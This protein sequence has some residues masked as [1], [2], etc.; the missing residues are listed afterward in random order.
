MPFTFTPNEY[1]DMLLIFGECQKNSRAAVHLYQQRFPERR[2]PS[3]KTYSYVETRMREGSFPGKDKHRQHAAA[4]RTEEMCINVLAYVQVHPQISTRNLAN[5]VHISKSSVQRILKSYNFHP[6]KIHL[7]QE[8]RAGDFERRI[9]LIA[10]F[11]DLM[12][13][14]PNILNQILWSDESRF[15]NNATVN[16]HNMHYWSPENPHW[17]RET[18]FQTIWGVNVWCGLF[19]GRLIGPY[20]FQGT[21]TGARYLHFLENALPELL[22]EIPIQERGAMWWQ[23]D[24]APP[25]NSN[26]VTQFLNERFENQWIGN[27]GP[28]RW[29][30][31]SPD[32]SPLDFFL[33]GYLKTVVFETQPLNLEDLQNKIVQACNNITPEMITASCTRE[34]IRRFEACLA[35]NGGHFEQF[36]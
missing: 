25:H 35:S 10:H 2:Q 7:H 4:V 1:V 17:V 5:E 9:T 31:R 8:L 33:W 11:E 22:E 14:N 12:E 21:L 15:H 32:L 24:G 13:R 26:L 23:Q 29:P 18:N 19:Q 30:A 27:S 34:L 6:F 28:L 16:R 3:R 36:L 20:F